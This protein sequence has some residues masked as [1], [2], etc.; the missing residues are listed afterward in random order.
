MV[1]LMPR[2]SL[3]TIF[4]W[5]WGASWSILWVQFCDF[6]WFGVAN[7]GKVSTSMF[8]MLRGWSWCQNAM[9]Q[10]AITLSKTMCFEWFHFFYLF[11]NSGSRGW[12]LAHIFMSFADP[13]GVFSDFWGSW[14]QAGNLMIFERF[15]GGAR[16]ESTR[17]KEGN[18]TVRGPTKQLNS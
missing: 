3:S 12:D 11:S 9:T 1:T 10:W 13:G 16:V 15:P 8:L 2:C 6:L 7:W 14:R 5:I 4:D 18:G 17:Q